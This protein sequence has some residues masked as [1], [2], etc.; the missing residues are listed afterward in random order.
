MLFH[1]CHLAGDHKFP[2]FFLP[3]LFR[4]LHCE[5][6]QSILF[7]AALGDHTLPIFFLR[8]KQLPYEIITSPLVFSR[9]VAVQAIC[10][11]L[12]TSGLPFLISSVPLNVLFERISRDPLNTSNSPSLVKRVDWSN[13]VFPEE[14]SFLMIPVLRLINWGRLP[15]F[16]TIEELFLIWI[17]RS[18]L[19]QLHFP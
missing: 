8:S 9:E 1:Y 3:S 2:Y 18:Y 15:T 4:K 10:T 11:P 17:I 13:I 16:L 14:D 6:I 12:S 5:M 7:K 19:P